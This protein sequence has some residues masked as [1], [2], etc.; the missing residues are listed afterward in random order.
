MEFIVTLQP[1]HRVRASA[2]YTIRITA[3]TEAGVP[4]QVHAY[5]REKYD[6]CPDCWRIQNVALR[7]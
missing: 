1:A 2:S 6:L 4:G 3:P 5:L 7:A